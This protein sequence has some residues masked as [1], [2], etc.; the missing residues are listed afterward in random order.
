MRIDRAEA[1][2][3]GKEVQVV[4]FPWGASGRAL[5]FDRTD[6]LTKLVI[7]TK[8]ER[9]LGVGI[10]GHGAGELIAEGV[11]AVE[12]GATAKDLALCVHPHPTLSETLMEAAEMFY[13]HATHTLSKK[14]V[15]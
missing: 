5:T 11:V 12:M 15:E 10:V 2:E 1:R 4:K 14:R 6:G 9:I 3:Q 8:T 13:G 7:D